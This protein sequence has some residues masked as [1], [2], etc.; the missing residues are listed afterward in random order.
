MH[1]PLSFTDSHL[2]RYI[3]KLLAKLN[4][5]SKKP[6]MQNSEERLGGEE[7]E[8]QL[9]TVRLVKTDEGPHRS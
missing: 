2:Y 7:L 5:I 8:P 6:A 9:V 4:I 1:Y 3:L